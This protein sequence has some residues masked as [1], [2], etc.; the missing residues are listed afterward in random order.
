M[1]AS[2]RIH[3][4]V[5]GVDTL[6]LSALCGACPQ[7]PRGCCAAPPVFT[8]SDIARILDHG[9]RDWL[10]AETTAGRL[11]PNR[12]GLAVARVEGEGGARCAFHGTRGCTLDPTQRSTTC[13]DYLCDDALADGARASPWLARRAGAAHRELAAIYARWD[14]EIGAAIGAPCWD[15]AAGEEAM[16]ATLAAHG[17]QLRASLPPRL[18]G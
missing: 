16:L 9:G 6:A 7:G 4:H 17:R 12:R 3:L 5:A 11:V 14:E 1:A 8:W 18:A 10:R 2:A 15:G 13:N